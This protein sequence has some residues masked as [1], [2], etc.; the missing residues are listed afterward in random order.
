MKK[1][2]KIILIFSVGIIICYMIFLLWQLFIPVG[3]QKF[4]S[5][6]TNISFNVPSKSFFKEECCMFAAN[7]TSLRSVKSLRKEI[8]NEL[9]KYEKIR[10]NN[11][12]YYYDI[13]QDFTITEY[14]I[15]KGLIF[16][17]FT[18]V[19]DKGKYCENNVD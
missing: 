13:T 9:K 18:I 19:Y 1:R 14:H 2:N 8:E 15:S 5:E 12:I 11:K 16:N 7:F 4:K 3:T 10:C 17:N 6:I